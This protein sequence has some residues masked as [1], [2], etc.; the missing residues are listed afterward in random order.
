MSAIQGP[1]NIAIN[2]QQT[3]LYCLPQ[4]TQFKSRAPTHP[5]IKVLI[6]I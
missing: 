5:F 3:I 4:K 1:Q 2:N 6:N